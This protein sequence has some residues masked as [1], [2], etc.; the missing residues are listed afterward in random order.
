M[1]N[2]DDIELESIM[3]KYQVN[4]HWILKWYLFDN[5]YKSSYHNTTSGRKDQ[6]MRYKESIGESIKALCLLLS[7]MYR[8]VDNDN[9]YTLNAKL[10]FEYENLIRDLDGIQQEDLE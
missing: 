5:V 3:K 6:I 10:Q 7:P 4:N 8:V 2:I 9:D 1:D